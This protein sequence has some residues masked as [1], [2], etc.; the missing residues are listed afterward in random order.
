VR[1]R[2]HLELRYIELLEF[3]PGVEVFVEQP[4][5]LTYADNQRQRTAIPDFYVE[6]TTGAAFV[7]IKWEEDAASPANE[8]RW[9]LIGAAFNE[10]GYEYRVVT[11]RT[12][13]RE[14]RSGN[15]TALL[16][17]R[18]QPLPPLEVIKLASG[19]DFVGLRS[20]DEIRHHY[21]GVPDDDLL[22]LVARGILHV[23]LDQPLHASPP[24][25][26]D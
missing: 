10:L 7:E 26:S 12:I 22:R 8:A 5:R 24:I 25:T 9:P 1:A 15:V 11:E 6:G 23:D 16:R 13:L 21:V 3:D 2:S 20:M 4:C 17:R 19:D 14:P 18:R